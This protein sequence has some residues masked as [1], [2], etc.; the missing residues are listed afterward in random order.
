MLEL[1]KTWNT[2]NWQSYSIYFSDMVA[3]FSRPVEEGDD[4]AQNL[5]NKLNDLGVVSYSDIPHDLKTK[6]MEKGVEFYYL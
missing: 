3:S 4:K 1:K 5:V 2:D 6:M